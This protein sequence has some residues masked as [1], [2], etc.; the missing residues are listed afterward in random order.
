MK[1]DAR[2]AF[3]N[4]LV[5]DAGE[6]FYIF[7]SGYVV[8]ASALRQHVIPY[9]NDRQRARVAE[10]ESRINAGGDYGGASPED[11]Q[12]ELD[13]LIAAE[14]P[15]TGSSMVDSIDREFEGCA[16]MDEDGGIFRSAVERAEV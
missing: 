10:L 12:T 11:L 5:L 2:C 13:G 9:L 4:R 16:E 6:P 3:T 7:P 14:C 1:G 15:L 8:L